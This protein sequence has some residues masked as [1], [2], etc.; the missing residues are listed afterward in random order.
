[1]KK[2]SGFTLIELM[3]VVAII[4][5]LASTA[6]PAYQDYTI[7]SRITEGLILASGAKQ[8]VGTDVNTGSALLSIASAWNTQQAGQGAQSKYVNSVLIDP[9]TGEVIVTFNQ[10]NVGSIPANSTIV[11]TPYIVSAGGPL[12]LTAALGAGVTGVIDWGCASDTN[13]VSSGA[14][15]NMPATTIG[16][17]PARFAPS[18]CR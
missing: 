4:G 3:I 10:T 1:M 15:R 6:L 13:L 14:S 7:R 12:T 16:T 17:L 8:I 18:E 9:V 11:F 5:I 2:M